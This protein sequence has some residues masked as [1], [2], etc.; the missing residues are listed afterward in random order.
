[1]NAALD[2][3]GRSLAETL[4][5]LQN[6]VRSQPGDAK[7]RTFLFQLLSVMG[8]WDRAINQLGVAGE[9]D[10]ATLAMVQMYREALK[11]E[12]LRAEVFAGKRSPVVFGD[13]EPWV[14]LVLEALKLSADGRHEQA[15]TL[16]AQAFEQAPATSGRL[17]TA[18]AEAAASGDDPPEGEP[19]EW[20][21]DADPRL[22]PILEVVVLGRYLWV[23]LSRISRIDVEAPTD[24]RD[25]VWAPVHLQWSN[26]GE[27]VGVIP[28]RYPGTE[29][30]TEDALRLSK[31]TEWQ[32]VSADVF[33][34]IGQRMLATDAGEYPLL[35]V[36]RIDLDAPAPA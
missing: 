23:P 17:F 15:A 31:R 30:S 28:T 1:M 29:A 25:L 2:L 10:P 9:L 22:G 3:K 18:A 8:Q 34:G 19:F 27:G 36:R 21:A 20:I 14:A 6:R 26:G 7:L 5:E 16:R 24:L 35:D 13:P 12:A 4:A 33:H 11:C 32:A